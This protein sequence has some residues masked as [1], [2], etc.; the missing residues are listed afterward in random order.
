MENHIVNK[1]LLLKMVRELLTKV[2]VY[3]KTAKRNVDYSYTFYEKNSSVVRLASEVCKQKS[4]EKV[5]I[6]A[7]I[8][9]KD[10]SKNN[11]FLSDKTIIQILKDSTLTASIEVTKA[12]NKLLLNLLVLTKENKYE[13]NYIGFI[14]LVV[15]KNEVALDILGK[16][17]SS[18]VNKSHKRISIEY[19]EVNKP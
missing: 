17:I 11:R 3:R 13:V 10:T 6:M 16:A 2:S 8:R 9:Y 14:V 5:S 4:A 1:R 19:K 12:D 15:C 7:T 18:L